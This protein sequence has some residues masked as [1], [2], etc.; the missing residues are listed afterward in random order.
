MIEYYLLYF[1]N[2]CPALWRKKEEVWECK[3]KNKNQWFIIE[4]ELYAE[5][6]PR[7]IKKYGQKLLT[8]Y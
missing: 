1:N 7:V 5:Y 3:Y 6:I 8:E 2:L 4:K